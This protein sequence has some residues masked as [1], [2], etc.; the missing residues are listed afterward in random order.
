MGCFTWP[1]SKINN[2]VLCDHL[3]DRPHMW[4]DTPFAIT[5]IL[6]ASFVFVQ[7]GS[8]A[9]EICWA[10]IQ[11]SWTILDMYTVKSAIGMDS[12]H[13]FFSVYF[14]AGSPVLFLLWETVSIICAVFLFIGYRS[15]TVTI[16]LWILHSSRECRLF[17]ALDL[18]D[19]LLR[20]ILFWGIFCNWGHSFSFDSIL[21]TANHL[22]WQSAPRLD[23]YLDTIVA[24][25]CFQIQ[26]VISLV[27][28]LW[29]LSR[30]QTFLE[31]GSFSL[32]RYDL[33]FIGSSIL[34]DPLS[35]EM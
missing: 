20:V 14:L 3:T 21:R 23:N 9:Y 31:G 12:A 32:L 15:T 34:A 16:L 4:A 8:W 24:R 28:F 10:M 17:E 29:S 11:G 6:V 13:D 19:Q 33:F 7:S 18:S 25:I 35:T 30:S 2:C 22:H 26:I 1:Q 5:R 27:A